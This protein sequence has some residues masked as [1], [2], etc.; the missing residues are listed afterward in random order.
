MRHAKDI[1]IL[2]IRNQV[3]RELLRK[4][5][6][7]LSEEARRLEQPH[8][9]R[10]IKSEATMQQLQAELLA[11]LTPEERLETEAWVQHALSCRSPVIQCVRGGV[12]KSYDPSGIELSTVSADMDLRY[13][14]GAA[15]RTPPFQGV[16]LSVEIGNTWK[17]EAHGL[18]LVTHPV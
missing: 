15:C 18:T 5:Q 6:G 8:R 16:S 12:T 13:A 17:L 9:G 2:H 14:F 1:S 4:R 11:E 7:P 10:Y 3:M